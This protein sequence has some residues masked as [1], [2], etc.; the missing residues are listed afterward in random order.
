MINLFSEIAKG[1]SELIQRNPVA[2][3]LT[4]A[5]IIA[6]VLV[7]LY[8]LFKLLKENFL[9]WLA[10]LAQTLPLVFLVLSAEWLRASLG[11]EVTVIIIAFIMYFVFTN[12][13][14]SNLI[15][16]ETGKSGNGR[17]V[18]IM[19]GLVGLAIW[20]YVIVNLFY[21][22]DISGSPPPPPPPEVRP[23]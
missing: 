16:I 17:I 15:Q 9:K 11:N 4:L 2:G 14:Y 5:L 18:L 22:F 10:P 19:L 23:S 20:I 3:Y 12:I 1:L 8:F 6:G 7:L 21:G 13:T